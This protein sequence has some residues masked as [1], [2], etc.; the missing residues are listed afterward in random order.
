VEPAIGRSG[1]PLPNRE[2]R[3]MHP[4]R[5]SSPAECLAELIRSISILGVVGRQG[6]RHQMSTP[7][8]QDCELAADT[9]PYVAG[10]QHNRSFE[11]A[12]PF[13][14]PATRRSHSARWRYWIP[15]APAQE[16]LGD[17]GQRAQFDA[18]EI[19]Q[20]CGTA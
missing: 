18:I 4:N 3:R 9:G 2:R 17:Q 16:P 19:S 5:L 6:H 12:R 20:V 13:I 1:N 15:L 11:Q 10:L 14:G 7:A 8:Q